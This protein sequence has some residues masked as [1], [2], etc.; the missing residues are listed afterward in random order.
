[1]KKLLSILC[2]AALLLGI[3]TPTLASSQ[4]P[5]QSVRSGGVFET[6]SGDLCYVWSGG[7]AFNGLA[8]SVRGDGNVIVST[9]ARDLSDKPQHT[10]IPLELQRF[11]GFFSSGG[12][13]YLVFIQNNREESDSVEVLRVVKYSADWQRLDAASVFGANTVSAMASGN[14]SF[15]EYGGMLYLHTSHLMYKSK[16]DGLNHQA[17]MTFSIRTSDMMVTD[18][19]TDVM[20]ISY[21]YVSHS[22]TQDIIV[23]SNGRIVTLDAGDA[24]PRSAV[25]YRYEKAA[26][27]PEFVGASG[28]YVNVVSWSGRIGANTIGGDTHGLVEVQSGYIAAY[29]DSGKGADY[30]SQDVMNGFISFTPKD[31]FTS[32]GTAITALTNYSQGS[33]ESV[34]DIFLVPTDMQGGYVFWST[35]AK[36]ENYGFYSLGNPAALYCAE[37]CADGSVGQAV[38][39]NAP[40]HPTGEITYIDGVFYWAD[41]SDDSIPVIYRYDGSRVI[42]S[43]TSVP[44]APFTVEKAETPFKDVPKSHWASGYIAMAVSKSLVQGDGKGSFNPAQSVTSA[45]WA[46]MISNL[47]YRDYASGTASDEANQVAAGYW[48]SAEVTACYDNGAL[49]GTSL[50]DAIAAASSSG[51]TAMIEA[52][53][54]K[55]ISRYDM[56]MV[57]Y[58]VASAENW[59]APRAP[60]AV[61]DSIADWQGIPARYQAAVAY[62][63]GNS[64]LNGTDDSGTFAGETTMTRAAAAT[65]L[66]RLDN[67]AE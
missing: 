31:N 64:L 17:N 27:G 3:V 66:C 40:V 48:W 10:V 35:M 13:N 47:M 45:Q 22:F 24:Y 58:N 23:D 18:Q 15:A 60:G 16:S 37:Y 62:C 49:N 50:G 2:A 59:G 53:A 55:P 11:G 4:S 51:D 33:A 21:G 25:L 28:E 5:A 8:E 41:I 36:D 32:G 54:G 61:S 44:R 1:M 67:E 63:Y 56:A 26:G 6:A 9:F 43:P 57:M 42:S 46:T 29:T 52:A 65:V 38:R 12:Y 20:N 30:R 39:I 19:W 7:K 14:M 34:R